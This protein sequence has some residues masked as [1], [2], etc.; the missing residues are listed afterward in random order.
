MPRLAVTSADVDGGRVYFSLEDDAGVI[1]MGFGKRRSGTTH[2]L[3]S[4]LRDVDRVA[5]A[6]AADGRL[7]RALVESVLGPSSSHVE[8]TREQAERMVRECNGNEREAERRFG[9]KR[10]KLRRALG[11]GGRGGQTT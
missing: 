7:S 2:F 5:A 1:A 3:D 11:K 9:V 4:G 8:L 6:L 10:G